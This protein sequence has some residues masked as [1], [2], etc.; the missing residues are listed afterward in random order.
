MIYKFVLLGAGSVGKSSLLRKLVFGDYQ[1]VYEP[2]TDEMQSITIT[3]DKK[4]CNIDLLDPHD[5]N[6][7][8]TMHDLYVL[9]S[10]AYILV[11]AVN[12][13]FSFDSMLKIWNKLKKSNKI[14]PVLC[15]GNKIDME[16]VIQKSYAENVAKSNNW[17][18]RETSAKEKNDIIDSIISL[19][20]FCPKIDNKRTMSCT[21]S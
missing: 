6:N 21:I 15:I 1:Q 14:K 7:W 12:D 18:Y 4:Q 16:R 20:K 3:I 2:T 13:A 17:I 10:N 19:I 5:A 8:S 9:N 11:Y